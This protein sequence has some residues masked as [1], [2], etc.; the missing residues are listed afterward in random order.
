L[1][2]FKKKIREIELVLTKVNIFLDQSQDMSLSGFPPKKTGSDWL[3][4]LFYQL[5]ACFLAG[6]HLNSC[7]ESDLRKI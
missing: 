3:S 5:E 7:H 6:N 4:Y 2:I 1:V